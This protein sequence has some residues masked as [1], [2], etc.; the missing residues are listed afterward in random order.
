MVGYEP[1]TI[2]CKRDVVQV[3]V[4][5][6]SKLGTFDVP[7]S[8]GADHC[9]VSFIEGVESQLSCFLWDAYSHFQSVAQ[10]RVYLVGWDVYGRKQSLHG[11]SCPVN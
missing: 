7:E 8:V 6:D 5:G 4:G 2:Q 1:G 9:F 10:V 11:Y 3:A